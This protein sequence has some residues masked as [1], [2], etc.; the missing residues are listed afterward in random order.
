MLQA[1]PVQ[2]SA[3]VATASPD[4]DFTS[5]T[6]QMSFAATAVTALSTAVFALGCCTGTTVQ[7]VPLK[8]IAS[9][10]APAEV[11]PISQISVAETAVM[12]EATKLV[13]G[14]VTVR[15]AVPSQ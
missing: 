13:S 6:A 8:F 3:R 7:V 2:W 5:P 1:L 14:R 10:V 9:A 4:A 11:L 12:D 15:H